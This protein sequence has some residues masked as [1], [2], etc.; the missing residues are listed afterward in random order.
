MFNQLSDF[1]FIRPLWLFALLAALLL[2]FLTEYR[3]KAEYQWRN[4][5][6]P[7][8]LEHLKIKGGARS[9]FRPIHLIIFIIIFGALALSGP[10]W[11]REQ[12]PFSEDLAPLVIALDLSQSMDAID[13]A[14]TRLERA[15]QKIADLLDLRQGARTALIVYAGSAHSVLPFT[16]DPSVLKTY[17]LSLRTDI[18]P[19][20]GKNAAK[21]L[22]LANMMLDRDDVPGTILFISDGIN[23]KYLN[24]FIKHDQKS[25]DQVVV[26]AF[27]TADG[28]PIK[29]DKNRFLTDRSGLRIIAKLDVEGLSALEAQ[30]AVNVLSLTVNN[31]DVQRLQRNIQTHLQTVRNED[32]NLRW[33][34]FGYY[35]VFPVVLFGLFWFR[36]GW[37]VQWTPLLLVLLLNACAPDEYPRLSSIWLTADQQGRYFYEKGDFNAA[38]EKFEDA[39]WKAVS[40]YRAGD[41][42]SAVD[43][44]ARS[45][46]MEA[47]Y[48]LANSY[49]WIG[50]YELAKQTYDSIL[51]SLPDWKAALE[52]RKIVDYLIKKPKKEDNEPP[53]QGDPHF[54]PDEIKFDDKGKKGK[55]GEVQMEK[56]SDEQLAEIWM[57]RLQT[58]PA[59][60]LRSKFALQTESGEKKQ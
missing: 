3:R 1:H 44:F 12:A 31:D 55:E 23:K 37:T 42:A 47:Q 39:M 50:Q 9:F 54:K 4:I 7:H 8:L 60:F 29:I 30:S 52:N 41:Y 56:L 46:S 6:A 15:K 11:Q 34:D 5:I 25:S 10:T 45:N 18:M 33:K 57:R 24:D 21:A 58:S 49:A 36:K 38:A 20:N 40:Y 59:D 26:L 16:D 53:P 27:G 14:P 22:E 43:W 2:Y 19:L 13:V 28:G 17:V 35:L 32:E 48:N 51:D